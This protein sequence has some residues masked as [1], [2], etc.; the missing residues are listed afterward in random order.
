MTLAQRE[1]PAAAEEFDEA[2]RW[3]ESQQAGVGLRLIDRAEQARAAIADWPHAAPPFTSLGDG[4]VIRS[5]TIRGFPLL[6]VYSAGLE[7][8][9]I[10]AYAHDHRRPG[11][12][13][14]R[15]TE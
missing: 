4:T 15:I 7:D 3:Y 6:I 13:A 5:K 12:W 11:Y 1:H 9:V 8:I 2:V 10:L 14:N